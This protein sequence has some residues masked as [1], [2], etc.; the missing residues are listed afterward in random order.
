MTQRFGGAGKLA[1]IGLAVAAAVAMPLSASARGH[2]YHGGGYYG[3]GYHGG[4][5]GGYYGHGG[6]WSGGR[7][8]AGAIVT[9]A[10]IGL[11]DNALRPAPV[12]Y[13]PP[14]TVI[15]EDAPVVRRRVV[16]TRT[17]VY[18]D[19]YQTRYIRDD[20]YDDDD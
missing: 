1:A 18:D 17:V 14:R 3:G 8:I 13:G 16:E 5:H 2:G 4:Y 6:H 15:Y 10:V 11:V 19:P 9:G 7:W 20:G 12:Y